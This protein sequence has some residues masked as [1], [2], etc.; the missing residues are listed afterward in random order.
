MLLLFCFVFTASAVNRVQSKEVEKPRVEKSIVKIEAVQL[1]AVSVEQTQR[2][3]VN[4][5]EDE[6][7][8]FPSQEDPNYTIKESS[9]VEYSA[10]ISRKRNKEIQSFPIKI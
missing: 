3:E 10:T 9:G 6:K 5:S 7:K 1:N 2:I 4:F 8:E